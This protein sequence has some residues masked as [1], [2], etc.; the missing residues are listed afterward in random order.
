MQKPPW[1]LR[2]GML[3]ALVC[4][5]LGTVWPGRLWCGPKPLDRRQIEGLVR[6]GVASQR[7]ARIITA[8]GIDFTPT[9]G[10]LRSLKKEGA[11][12]VLLD[13]VE[14]AVHRV[15]RNGRQHPATPLAAPLSADAVHYAEQYTDAQRHFERGKQFFRQQRWPDVE[16]EMSRAAELDPMN[17]EAH[18]DLGYALSQ[19][20]KLP[21][22]I[23]EYRR[24]LQLDP[25]AGAVHY[26]LG[27]AL[28]KEHDL[29]AAI[30]EYRQA[31]RLDPDDE[32]AAYALGAALYEQ[33]D[34]PGAAAE[35]RQAIRLAPADAD[36]H[37]ALGLADLHQQQVDDAIPELSEALRLNPQNALAHAALA[38]ALLRKGERKAALK[39]F[40]VALALNPANSGYRADFQN[41]WRQLYPPPAH[42]AVNP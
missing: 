16:T 4:L 6:G 41:L 20:G 11:Q 8:R 24:V 36:A 32:S 17:I 40:R 31:S 12:P 3:C 35:L 27:V 21:D 22:A 25:D 30:P 1:Q 9:S 19:Q 28:E 33:N 14:Q 38:G 10:F 5:L 29:N 13:S 34:W 18:F 15:A 39:E 23:R 37:C 7:I 2:E 42:S 26:D